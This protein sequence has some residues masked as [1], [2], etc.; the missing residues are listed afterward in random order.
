MTSGFEEVV[1]GHGRPTVY[2]H[3]MPEFDF[4]VHFGLRS[5]KDCS[6]L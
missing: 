3:V 5:E 2:I 6:F 1:R 4:S